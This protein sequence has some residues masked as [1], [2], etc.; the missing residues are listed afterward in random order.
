MQS[1]RNLCGSMERDVAKKNKMQKPKLLV[2]KLMLRRQQGLTRPAIKRKMFVNNT[3]Q[4]VHAPKPDQQIL[5]SGSHNKHKILAYQ[6][7]LHF[8]EFLN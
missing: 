3:H 1:K 8:E 4:L 7:T 6:L 5:V 2:N